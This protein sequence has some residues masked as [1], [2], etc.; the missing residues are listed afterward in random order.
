[1]KNPICIHTNSYLR[2]LLMILA[3]CLL[4]F[5]GCSSLDAGSGKGLHAG[6]IGKMDPRSNEDE[7]VVAANRDWYQMID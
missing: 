3:I 5:S 6:L 1:M 4:G 2:S 7:D